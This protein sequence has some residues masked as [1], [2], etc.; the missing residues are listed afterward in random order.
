MFGRYAGSSPDY[1]ANYPSCEL[2]SLKR[3]ASLLEK[4]TDI[5]RAKRERNNIAVRRSREKKKQ[6]EQENEQRVSKLAEE[7]NDLQNRLDVVLKEMNL[8]KS[9]YKN[10]GI[11]LPLEARHKI[12]SEIAKM[13]C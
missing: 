9:L 10:I 12:E 5:Y 1:L 2:N 6:R 3:N 11:A 4:N 7:N 8:L 13:H